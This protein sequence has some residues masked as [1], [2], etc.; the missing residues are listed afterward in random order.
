MLFVVSKL[1]DIA[2]D[3]G[4]LLVLFLA[5]AALLLALGRRRAG[6]RIVIGVAVAALAVAILPVNEWVGAP[7]ENR[8]PQPTLPAHVDGIVLLGGAVRVEMSNLR[9]EVTLNALGERI[10]ATVALARRYP[11]APVLLSGGDA[12]LIPRPRIVEA[13]LTK[14][15]MVSLGVDPGRIIVEGRSRNTWENA[16]YSKEAA[17]PA[18]GQVWL[19]VTSANHMPRAVGCF[20]KVGFPVLPYPVAYTTG[21]PF[22]L[23]F[24]LNAAL[25]PLG[26]D[27]HEWL[28]LVA[29]RLLGRTDAL[30]PGPQ[31]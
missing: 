8:F 29:Y 22:G 20:R 31:D 10:T 9:H 19:L 21:S 30:L 1:V 24:D 15:L 3:P 14:T 4:N 23:S 2:I 5:L 6:E 12:A 11:D 17:H 7:L 25:G 26:D 18:S 16:L 28:G 13:A 27:L